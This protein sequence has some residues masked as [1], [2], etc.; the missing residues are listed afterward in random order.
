MFDI[1]TQIRKVKEQANIILAVS[2]INP[3]VD[4]LGIVQRSVIASK[5]IDT[6][7]PYFSQN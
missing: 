5:P 1:K 4:A 6:S 3:E 2:E 7:E